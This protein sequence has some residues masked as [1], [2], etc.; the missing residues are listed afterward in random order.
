[1]F[2]ER[3][4]E[5]FPGVIRFT[6]CPQWARDVIFAALPI[7][8]QVLPKPCDP[9]TLNN[10]IERACRL[11]ALLT[12]S[13]RQKIGNIEKLPS[14]PT[15]YRELMDVMSRPDV[16][17]QKIARVVEKDSAMAA[18][19]LQ[20]VNSACFS[21]SYQI[22]RLDQAVAYLGMELIKNLSLSIHVFSK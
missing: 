18:K 19:T 2:L 22:T 12:D 16:S 4:K 8:H 21:V 15:V 11:R 20:L 1:Q 3:V 6:L 10:V 13:M 17:A 5:E 7:S 14:L 9:D